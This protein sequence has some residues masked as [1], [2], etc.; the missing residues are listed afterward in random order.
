MGERKSVEGDV[1]RST[2]SYVNDGLGLLK[3][4]GDEKALFQFTHSR[5]ACTDR[6]MAKGLYLLNSSRQWKLRQCIA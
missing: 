3:K 5:S 2:M 1:E 4:E 6:R